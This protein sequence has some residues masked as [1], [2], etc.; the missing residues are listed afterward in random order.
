M[1]I[2]YFINQYPKVSHS[3]VR[4]EILA[5]E[6]LGRTV[7][8]W[9]LR[10]W[11]AEL[12]DPVDLAE[13]DRTR[14]LLRG[15]VAPLLIA[16][17]AMLVRHPGRWFAA[18]RLTLAM[19]RNTDRSI[20]LH[21]ISF[22]EG[23][24]LAREMMAADVRHLHA[25]FGTNAAEIAMLGATMAGITYSFTVH[26]PDEFDRPLSTKLGLK[27]ARAAHVVAITDFCASQL[28]R[29]AD[30]QDWRKVK[31]VRCGLLPDFLEATLTPPAEAPHFVCI[32]RLSGQKG[33]LLLIEGL[34]L[35]RRQGV[36]ATLTLVG[37][38]EMRPEIEAAIAQ[39]DLGA[40]VTITGWADERRVRAELERARAMVM[41]S[42]AEGLPIVVMEAL[43]LG[44]P[45]LATN[46]AAMAD[47]VRNGE[48]GWLYT[49]GSVEAIAQA[50][51]ECADADDQTLATMGRTGRALVAERHDQMR[52][53]AKLS[54]LL[55]SDAV[56]ANA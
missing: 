14:F 8:R 31:V 2:G 41:A 11:D 43:A 3:F 22:L 7:H 44:R 26:G 23:A 48:T 1:A 46:V 38:G 56:A 20:P 51:R 21:L 12:V 55:S 47:L 19:C 17:I 34:A 29:W 32:G 54:R 4:R 5:L 49:P 33:Q 39:H 42:F 50:I 28:Y 40:H 13:R 37:D 16:G 25:H 15:G 35:A 52:E 27:I 53:A 10:G 9:A 6:A 30:L 24:R 36:P 45:V 18:L